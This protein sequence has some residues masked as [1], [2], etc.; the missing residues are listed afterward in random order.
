MH[1]YTRH[2]AVYSVHTSWLQLAYVPNLCT[3]WRMWNKLEKILMF[4]SS[5]FLWGC[6]SCSMRIH[7]MSVPSTS[8]P[9]SIKCHLVS[10]FRALNLRRHF[11]V[12]FKRVQCYRRGFVTWMIFF[13]IYKPYNFPDISP[14]IRPPS[15]QMSY[16]VWSACWIY[17]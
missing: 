13:K 14:S 15:F 8:Y 17:H 12:C 7:V 11:M 16:S 5:F 6:K 2:I 1:N 10:E 3:L 4:F 9:L